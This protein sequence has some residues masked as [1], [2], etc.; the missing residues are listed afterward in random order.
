MKQL[1]DTTLQIFILLTGIFAIGFCLGVLYG[2][3]V[4]YNRGWADG[5]IKTSDKFKKSIHDLEERYIKAE[6][7][8]KQARDFYNTKLDSLIE[9]YE[10]I[11]NQR[12]M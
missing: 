3:N 2:K 6:T 5:S 1:S 9:R 12:K 11:E 8:Y 4:F 10:I 7:E